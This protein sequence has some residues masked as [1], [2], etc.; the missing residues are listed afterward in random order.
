MKFSIQCYLTHRCFWN[1]LSNLICGEVIIINHYSLPVVSVESHSSLIAC[2]RAVFMML[3]PH[4]EVLSAWQLWTCLVTDWQ[5]DRP[6]H[7]G[8]V[9]S[10][11][12]AHNYNYLATDLRQDAPQSLFSLISTHLGG[13]SSYII[14]LCCYVV[15]S[16]K[17]I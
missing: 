6:H 2:D 1:N 7:R 8:T 12:W 15:S 9:F 4:P 5:T 10:S 17:F 11:A 16:Y 14:L 13:A 3:F